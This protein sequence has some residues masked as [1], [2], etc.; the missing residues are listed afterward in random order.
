[1]G[2]GCLESPPLYSYDTESLELLFVAFDQL[3]L[4]VRTLEMD[5][6]NSYLKR[7]SPML[8]LGHDYYLFLSLLLDFFFG[9]AQ[10]DLL[11]ILEES[12]P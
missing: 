5:E 9:K 3:C 11:L 4:P 2:S 12:P 1:M 6:L 8:T 7:G 10:A